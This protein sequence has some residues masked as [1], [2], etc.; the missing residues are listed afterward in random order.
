MKK[1]VVFDVDGTL[2]ESK[3][4]V[5]PV[6]ANLLYQLLAKKKVGIISGG[7][8]A[9]MKKQVLDHLP[10]DADRF[11]NL[12]LFPEKGGAMYCWNGDDWARI[13]EKP[14]A[15]EDRNA[16]R[17]AFK[18]VST[19]VDFL[20][21][22]HFGPVFED[23]GAEVTFSALGQHAP[24]MEKKPWDPD[25]KKR[26]RLKALL[27]PLLPDFEIEIGGTTS[28]N[29]TKKGVDKAFALEEF[30]R[31]E[32]LSIADVLYI[33]DAIYPGGNDF[34]VTRTGVD[35]AIVKD[36]NETKAIIRKIIEGA[37]EN[38]I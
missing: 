1:A 7:G 29:I 14:L 26:E 17:T 6:T 25:A 11:E 15:P 18:K 38:E 9:Q 8:L 13:Y 19:G 23:L 33:G 27:E 35:T 31:R 16:I 5:D 22:E 28:I 10:A 12:F 24:I 21:S 3:E 34:S 30:C 36:Y 37:Y 4:P 2:S 32:H 20:P